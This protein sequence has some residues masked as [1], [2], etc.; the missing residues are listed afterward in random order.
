MNLGC[1]GVTIIKDSFG[2]VGLLRLRKRSDFKETTQTL[3]VI[4]GFRSRF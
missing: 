3:K 1:G 2:D 4:Y